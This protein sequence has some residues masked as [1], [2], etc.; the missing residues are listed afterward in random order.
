MSASLSI[1]SDCYELIKQVKTKDEL[2]HKYHTYYE[3][4]IFDYLRTNYMSQLKSWWDTYTL[5][6]VSETDKCIVIY[7]TRKHPNLEFLIYNLT[8]FARGWGLIIY[9][10]KENHNY[11]SEILKH[12]SFR[13]L[14][15]I[16][17]E[18]EGGRE[19]REEYNTF[20]KSS[21]FW[22]SLSC[23]YILMCEMDGYLRKR[24]PDDIVNYDYVCC[25]W[26]WNNRVSGGGGISF[27]KVASMKKIATEFPTLTKDYFGQD[28]WVAEGS[29]RLNLRCNNSYLVEAD[30]NNIDPIGFHNWWT[31]INP[32]NVVYLSNIYDKYLTLEL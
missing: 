4:P 21:Q 27:R 19:V 11:I 16:V 24:V 30:H 2:L 26:P 14:L 3:T 1:F 22:D 5:P 23:N 29:L 9:C 13:A 32:R 28:D 31:F 15:Y 17:R 25:Y 8:Y 7:E 12:N 10:S 18:N 20:V 6:I